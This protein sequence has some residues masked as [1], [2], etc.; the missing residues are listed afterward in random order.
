MVGCNPDLKSIAIFL[1]A[2]APGTVPWPL[3]H[4]EGMGGYKR[5]ID[6]YSFIFVKTLCI[7]VNSGP[8]LTEILLHQIQ[9]PPRL[10]GFLQNFQL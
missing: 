8:V 2:F 1:N 3:P 10:S 5:F 6:R 4:L 7:P 9:K